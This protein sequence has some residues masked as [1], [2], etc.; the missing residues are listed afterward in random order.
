MRFTKQKSLREHYWKDT[1]IEKTKFLWLPITIDSE[2][3]W[4]E[5][6]TMIYEVKSFNGFLEDRYFEWRPVKFVNK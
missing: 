6:T 1:K 4:L 2:T 5:K 3:R